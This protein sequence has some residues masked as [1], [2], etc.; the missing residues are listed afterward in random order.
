[1]RN[2]T[3]G[4]RIVETKRI[5]IKERRPTKTQRQIALKKYYTVNVDDLRLL[6]ADQ[7][8]QARLLQ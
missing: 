3:D 1:M 6:T 2:K 5:K 7:S 8:L 4:D